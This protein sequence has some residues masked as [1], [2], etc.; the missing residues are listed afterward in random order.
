MKVTRGSGKQDRRIPMRPTLARSLCLALFVAA[1]G[2]AA[3][4]GQS[5]VRTSTPPPGSQI[6]V[7][8]FYES[9]APDGEWFPQPTYGWCWTPYDVSADWRP[10]SDGHWEYTDY[11]WSWA[12]NE[13]WGWATYHYGRWFFD[14]SYGWVWVPGTEW[15]PAW[16]AWRYGDD[17][18]GW[19]PLPPTA[20]WDASAGLAFADPSAIQP[21]EWCFVPQAHMLDV[22]IRIQ[23]A[24]VGRNV[25][26]LERSQDATRFE[27]RDG[28]PANVGID[29]AQV[30]TMSGRRVPHVKIVDVDTPTRGG[31]RPAGS[32]T[33]GF[34]RPA[35][36]PMPVQ[37]APPPAVTQ[38]RN[39][40]PDQE[41][42]RVRD[43]QQR[44]LESDLNAEHARLARDQQNELRTQTPGPAVDEIRKRHAT[45]Q[46]AFEAHAAQQRQ[47]LAQRI[48]K[49]I[50]RPGKGNA[51]KQ[52]KGNNDNGKGNNGNK[53]GQ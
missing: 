15:A 23:V 9:L 46:Q 7:S 12:S 19:A 43:Q 47:V 40:I 14:D 24:S 27:V 29:V 38:P 8:Y 49:Q 28:R 6:D 25:T 41:L 16:V 26:L 22:S 32:G 53:G 17:Y 33:I 48:Q 20:N 4:N 37:Q 13:P 50:V 34:Y 51:G 30:E 45:E 5:D 44:K 31:G 52:G 36:R 2:C 35:V 1:A 10:Y 39:P 18:V 21:H 3:T 11:G 42:Q